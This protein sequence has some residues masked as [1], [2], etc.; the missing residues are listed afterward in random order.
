MSGYFLTGM[1]RGADKGGKRAI[2]GDFLNNCIPAIRRGIIKRLKGRSP[3]V[4]CKCIINC[5]IKR[6]EV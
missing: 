3:T 6:K 1:P 4:G 2:E 5:R